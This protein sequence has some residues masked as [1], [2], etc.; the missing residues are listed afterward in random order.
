MSETLFY[1]FSLAEDQVIVNIS[2]VDKISKSGT[3]SILLT[4]GCY[5]HKESSTSV[6][7]VS[8][9]VRNTEFYNLLD[10]LKKKRS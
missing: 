3:L 10:F 1:Q 4:K 6:S 5:E 8:E 2:N 7:F 9:Y